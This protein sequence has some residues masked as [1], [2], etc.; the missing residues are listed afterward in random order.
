MQDNLPHIG[1]FTGNPSGLT[2]DH[3]LATNRNHIEVTVLSTADGS[4]EVFLC[5]HG[6]WSGAT[7]TNITQYVSLNLT[8]VY[9][10]PTLSIITYTGPNSGANSRASVVLP[11]PIN[12]GDVI[13]IEYDDAGN[14]TM[15]LNGKEVTG[16]TWDDTGL[17]VA[18][19]NTNR[20]CGV[21]TAQDGFGAGNVGPIL[22]LLSAYD[23]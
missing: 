9:P 16:G 22:G 2:G 14:F 20:E 5:G 11:S 15:F 17:V 1:L 7:L 3:G 18:H 8:I 6:T 10:T 23:F 21:I 12:P 13:A 4:A 19:G